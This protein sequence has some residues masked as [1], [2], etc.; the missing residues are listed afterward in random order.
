MV[1]TAVENGQNL[2]VEGCYIPPGWRRDFGE[3]YLRSIGFVCLAMSDAYID[4]HIGE[5]R[6]YAC[7]IEARLDDS[8]CTLSELKEGNHR[9]IDTFA[10]CGEKVTIVES[11]FEATIEAVLEQFNPV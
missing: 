11:D 1:K 10:E 3:E 7:A 4:A 9:C 6:E 5:I 8:G 2:I